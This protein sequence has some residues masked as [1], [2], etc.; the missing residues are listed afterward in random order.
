MALS[1]ERKVELIADIGQLLDNSK[2]TVVAKY[3]GTSVK[4]LQKL[5]KESL[6]NGTKV[7]V[8]KNRLV[9]KAIEN[10]ER[11]KLIDTNLFSGQLLYAFNAED[12]A[13][14]AQNLAAFAKEEPQIEFVGALTAD[15][16]I[17]SAEDVAV[18]AALPTINELRSQLAGTIAAPLTGFA[19]TVS[20]NLRG[21]LNVLSARSEQLS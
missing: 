13:A 21:V 16:R 20:G 1:R 9:K 11:F 3:P 8:L 2:L 17:L 19:A 6:E 12:E 4:S 14:P 10:N 5:R 7:R 18:L 15:G